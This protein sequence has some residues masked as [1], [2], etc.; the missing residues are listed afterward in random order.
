MNISEIVVNIVKILKDGKVTED[1][2][3]DVAIKN[4]LLTVVSV[5]MVVIIYVIIRNKLQV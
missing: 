3:V 1:E 4:E 2:L 5:I